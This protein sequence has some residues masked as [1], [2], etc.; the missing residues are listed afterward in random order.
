MAEPIIA[1]REVTRHILNRFGIRTQKKL[2]QHFLVDENVVRRIADSLELQPGM[3]VLEIG[4]GIG[5]LTQFLA[6][7]G[8]RVTAVELDRRC[9]EIMGTTLKAYN[10]IRI[11]QGDVLNLDFAD[12]MGTGP[13]QIAGNLPYYI[14]TPIV[15]KILEGQVPAEKMVFM[16]QKEVADRMVAGPGG[17]D[18]GALSVAVQYHTSAVKLF[19]VSA[20]AFLPP[21]AVDSAVILCTKRMQP[22]VDV[23]STKLF[24]GWCGRR[25]VNGEKRW[26][27]RCKAADSP[28]KK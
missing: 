23:P 11:V 5:T 24:F 14:T 26:R 17:K 16:V 18:Y 6:M 21:P 9:I 13:F 28:R 8:A 12:L 2:G 20:T 27:I 22:P 1:Q 4:P 3:P 19:E 10:N 25:L 7:T 15:M